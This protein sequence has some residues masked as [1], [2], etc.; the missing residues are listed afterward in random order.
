MTVPQAPDRWRKSSHSAG[1]HTCIE[2]SPHG[3][4]RDSKNPTGPTLNTDLS[5]LTTAIHAGH[6]DR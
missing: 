5:H 3:K 2:L 4:I 1:E 6:L